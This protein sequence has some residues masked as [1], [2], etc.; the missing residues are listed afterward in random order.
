MND[1]T[2]GLALYDFL[3]AL[4]TGVALYCLA[5]MVSRTA[6]ESRWLA[7]LGGGLVVTAGVLKASWKLVVATSGQ[8]VVLLSEAMFPL[9]GPGF[10]LVAFAVWSS[11]RR[12]NGRTTP[13]HLGKVALGVVAVACVL[14]FY[15]TV[16]AGNERGYFPVFLMVASVAN[17]VLSVLL[18]REA[19]R[20]GRRGAALLF[21]VNIAMV[22]AL[23]PIAAMAEP[24]IAMHWFEQTLTSGGAAAF[25]LASWLLLREV[26]QAQ[27]PTVEPLE[28]ATAN[29]I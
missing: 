20:H 5:I 9:M 6:P 25:A 10:A 8:D 16:I 4:F 26:P 27:T 23:Q 3:P 22:F 12:A 13:R 19:L 2:I 14:A 11:V 18:I 29:S 17:V 15:S 7:Y 1:Y 21:F 28:W 24:S